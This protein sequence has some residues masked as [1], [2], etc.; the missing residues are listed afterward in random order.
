MANNNFID[1]SR[2]EKYL[3]NHK[4]DALDHLRQLV[5]INSFT[6]NSAGVNEVG[7][8]LRKLFQP[9]GFEAQTPQAIECV[10]SVDPPLGKHLILRRPG[11]TNKTI[12]LIGRLDTVFT[13]ED[14]K[15]NN[16]HWHPEGERTYGPGTCDIQ[17]GNVQIWIVLSALRET[18]PQLFDDINWVVMFNAAEEGLASDFGVIERQQLGENALANLVFESSSFSDGASH[19]IS[20]RKGRARF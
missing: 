16:F 3:K 1:K 12:G 5:E 11:K 14:E 8:L 18:A 7:D 4:D 9:L 10:M 15:E 20:A 17:G 6:H 19:L 2:L 13:N